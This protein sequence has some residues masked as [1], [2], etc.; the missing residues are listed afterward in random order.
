MIHTINV[1]TDYNGIVIF[2]VDRLLQYFGGAIRDDTDIFELFMTT[3]AGDEVLDQGIVIPILAI[4]DAGYTVTFCI[5]EESPTAL[6]DSV[7]FHS[8]IFPLQVQRRLVI[9][10]LVVFREWEMDTDWQDVPVPPGTYSA[11]VEGYAV[12]NDAHEIIDCGYNLLLRTEPK[13]P[14]RTAS[15]DMNYRVLL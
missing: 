14:K 2:D 6:K 5:D 13:L 15:T 8:E 1:N 3:N 12:R 4:D 10:D 11:V 7:L 9:A